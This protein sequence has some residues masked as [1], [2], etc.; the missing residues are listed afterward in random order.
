[1]IMRT[2]IGAISGRLPTR[3]SADPFSDSLG[4]NRR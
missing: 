2:V 3:I 4:T 1:M